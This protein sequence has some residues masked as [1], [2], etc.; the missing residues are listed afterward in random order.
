[1]TGTGVQF[2]SPTYSANENVGTVT[3]TVTRGTNAG[4][5]TVNYATVTGGTAIGATICGG[6]ADYLTATGTLTWA[7]GENGAKTFALTICNDNV[8]ESADTVNLALTN[9]TGSATLGS[10]ATATLTIANDDLCSFMVSPTMQNFTALGGSGNITVTAS[11]GCSWNATSSAP[12]IT[13]TSAGIGDGTA[14]FNVAANSG[15]ARNGTLVIG[16]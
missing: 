10:P 3:I 2:T 5:A 16:G 9:P 1:L 13:S 8:V 4:V 14:T 11:S 7:D 15:Q 6:N 12:W